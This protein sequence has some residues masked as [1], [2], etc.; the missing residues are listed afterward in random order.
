MIRLVVW[1][2]SRG[3]IQI[4]TGVFMRGKSVGVGLNGSNPWE[5]G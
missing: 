3:R 4:G 2:A 1:I 5:E